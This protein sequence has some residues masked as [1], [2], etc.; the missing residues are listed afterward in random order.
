MA[1]YSRRATLGTLDLALLASAKLAADLARDQEK[2][3]QFSQSTAG[4]PIG[5]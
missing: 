5:R 1:R 2:S 4:R 3:G